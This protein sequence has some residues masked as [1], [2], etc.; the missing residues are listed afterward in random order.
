MFLRNQCFLHDCFINIASITN[1][2]CGQDAVNAAT[3]SS[4]ALP[5]RQIVLNLS[6]NWATPVTDL[7]SSMLD[8]ELQVTD[9]PSRMG[10]FPRINVVTQ[11]SQSSQ[12]SLAQR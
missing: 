12:A 7:S 9:V 4:K 1:F 2:G 6:L 5:G 10:I 11:A 8:V 3:T